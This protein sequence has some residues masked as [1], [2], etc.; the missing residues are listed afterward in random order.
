[1]QRYFKTRTPYEMLSIVVLTVIL[2]EI[3][4]NL[5]DNIVLPAL[6]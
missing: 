2:I 5:F 4:G 3:V 1:M 6:G